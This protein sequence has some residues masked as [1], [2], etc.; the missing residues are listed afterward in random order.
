MELSYDCVLCLTVIPFDSEI[1][2]PW[3]IFSLLY[4]ASSSW[5]LSFEN[6]KNMQFTKRRNLAVWDVQAPAHRPGCYTIGAEMMDVGLCVFAL[7]M[8]RALYWIAK[9]AVSLCIIL[10]QV[11]RGWS[12]WR[13]LRIICLSI[14]WCANKNRK[15]KSQRPKL[16]HFAPNRLWGGRGGI[17]RELRR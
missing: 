7:C 3:F 11:K 13:E 14:C 17:C 6:S 10:H 8:W 2:L 1:M 16:D 5:Y 12:S 9:T 15:R 4:S